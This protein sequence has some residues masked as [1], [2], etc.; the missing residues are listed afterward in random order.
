MSMEDTD[1]ATIQGLRELIEQK[2]ARIA[3]L[4]APFLWC[5]SCEKVVPAEEVKGYVHIPCDVTAVTYI[6][7]FPGGETEGE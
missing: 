3:E 6:D 5:E 4:E 2:D 7:R 1:A